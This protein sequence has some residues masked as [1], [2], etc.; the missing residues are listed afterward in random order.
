MTARTHTPVTVIS[1]AR[2]LALAQ[3]AQLL[4]TASVTY[5][6]AE[7]VVA[8]SAGTVAG[9]T[10][11]IGF[12]LDSTV[13]V[14]SGLVILWQFRHPMPETRERRAQRLIAVS[15]FALAGY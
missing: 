4:A 13:E 6:V 11:L 12:G 3:R 5:N 1:P 10:A 9:S 14:A 15:F 8:I 2:R 7:A